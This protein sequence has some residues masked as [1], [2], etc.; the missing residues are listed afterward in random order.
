MQLIV[1]RRP[2]LEALEL[3]RKFI[4]V[5][6]DSVPTAHAVLLRTTDSGLQLVRSDL[7]DRTVTCSI[8]AA[9]ETRG[10]AAVSF[11][12]LHRILKSTRGTSARMATPPGSQVFR[13]AIADTAALLARVQHAGEIYPE[14]TE[15]TDPETIATLPMPTLQWLLRS[16]VYAAGPP[17]SEAF[18]CVQVEITGTL[19]RVLATDGRRAAFAECG[20]EADETTPIYLPADTAAALLALKAEQMAELVFGEN[21]VLEI[22]LGSTARL[23]CRTLDRTMPD[24]RGMVA[25][26]ESGHPV[27]VQREALL[28][29]LDRAEAVLCA[30]ATTPVTLTAS[31][32]ELTLSGSTEDGAK[33][34]ERLPAIVDG[35][36]PE[37]SVNPTLAAEALRAIAGSEVTLSLSHAALMVEPVVAAQ[38]S[39]R[40]RAVLAS[41]RAA[42]SGEK[43][44]EEATLRL[45]ERIAPA[46]GSVVESVTITAGDGESVTLTQEDH[47]RAKARRKARRRA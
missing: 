16:V 34:F 28:A 47:E 38:I 29:A 15:A 17:D 19:V 42:N 33:L 13:L 22:Q 24:V 9:I 40:Q 30:G 4:A 21:K 43:D 2:M 32:G 10:E 23:R 46:P 18:G 5:S 6:K 26:L 14:S 3:A 35:E 7:V 41:M 39:E 25:R 37:V 45:V 31:G 1:A 11:R 36:A 27:I 44:N 8:D 20:L 12:A